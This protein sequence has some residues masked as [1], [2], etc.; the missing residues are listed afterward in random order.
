M[1]AEIGKAMAVSEAAALAE[2]SADSK[3]AKA[4]AAIDELETEDNWSR[5]HHW[6]SDREAERF[7]A[8][9]DRV[10]AVY[11]AA[12]QAHKDAIAAEQA[13]LAAEAHQVALSDRMERWRDRPG[14]LTPFPFV[15]EP[16]VEPCNQIDLDYFAQRPDAYPPDVREWHARFETDLIAKCILRVVCDAMCMEVSWD[17]FCH[18]M[19]GPVWGS[20]EKSC[21]IGS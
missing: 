15:G 8:K 21:D 14:A 2:A 10:W 13:A 11:Y 18:D 7:K 6:A 17:C 4:E 5:L 1:D 9:R 19:T 12:Q 3:R 20:G 16:F